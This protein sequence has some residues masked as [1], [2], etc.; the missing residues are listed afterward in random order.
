MRDCVEK[1]EPLPQWYLM[2]DEDDSI[3][4]GCGLVENDFVD[5]TH[6][7][8]YFCALYVEE[9]ARGQALGARL[10]EHVRRDCATLGFPKVYLCTDHVGL[11]EKYGWTHIT[12]G[13]HPWGKSSKIYVADALLEEAMG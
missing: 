9:N 2:L 8:P 6:L 10:L 5:T 11:Y 7:S 13:N 4:A 3:V 12:Y 1:Q